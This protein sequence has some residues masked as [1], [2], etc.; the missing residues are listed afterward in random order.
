MPQIVS[1][2]VRMCPY[3]GIHPVG[4]GNNASISGKKSLKVL[5]IPDQ[6]NKTGSEA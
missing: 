4:T 6:Y 5:A 2:L 1:L 3:H